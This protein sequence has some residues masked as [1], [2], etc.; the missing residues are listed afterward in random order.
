MGGFITLYTNIITQEQTFV[1][2]FSLCD[3]VLHK[4][5]QT[6]SKWEA[7]KIESIKMARKMM[8][9]GFLKRGLRMEQCSQVMSF[10]KCE[11]C[12]NSQIHHASLCRDKLCPICK[13][14]LATKRYLAMS[15][16]LH[17][18]S[19]EYPEAIY[20]FVTLTVPNCNVENLSATLKSMSAQWNKLLQRVSGKRSI[21]WARSLEITYNAKTKQVHPHYHCI[22]MY[23]T[24]TEADLYGTGVVSD[25]VELNA[26]SSFKAQSLKQIAKKDLDGDISTVALEVFKY[27]TKDEDLDTMPLSV[28][29]EFVNQIGG[30]RMVSFGGWLKECKRMVDVDMETATEETECKC[31]FCGSTNLHDVLCEWS[32]IEAQYKR[33][34]I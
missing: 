16:I 32:G 10:S 18:A 2:G 28:F 6:L 25:W 12:D 17:I 11:D 7:K 1:K 9:A 31:R 8:K 34:V 19:A 14:R 29:R 15:E 3:E 20:Q 21:G 33:L 23:G 24:Q 30:K 13:W 27:S 5:V 22:I 26:G 4:D